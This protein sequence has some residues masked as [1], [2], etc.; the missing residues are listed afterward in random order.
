MQK[1]ERHFLSQNFYIPQ[2]VVENKVHT[3]FEKNPRIDGEKPIFKRIV[4]EEREK[5]VITMLDKHP[6]IGRKGLA[7]V[8]CFSEWSRFGGHQFQAGDVEELMYA[9]Y[10]YN[11]NEDSASGY[12]W[13]R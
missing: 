4:L 6:R 9:C 10:R 5:I 12:H 11:A 2:E 3:K 8:S 7:V 13:R 1:G